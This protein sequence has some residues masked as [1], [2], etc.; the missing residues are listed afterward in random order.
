MF[1]GHFA[2]GFA[3]KRL[4]P[5]ASLGTLFMAAQF[6]DLLWPTFLLFGFERVIIE[7]GN[8]PF[9]PLNFVHYPWSH[10]LVAVINW[11][12]L[13][14]ATYFLIR[15]DWRTGLILGLVVISHWVLD[16]VT[17][18]PDLPLWPGGE[19]VGLGLWY[20]T[21]GTLAVEITF[22]VLGILMYFRSTSARD[23]TGQWTL[24]ILIGLLFVIY[25]GNVFGP[26]PPG[27]EAIAWVGQAQWLLVAFGYWVDRHR[28]ID[29]IAPSSRQF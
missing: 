27:V 10:S 28:D 3:G 14:G 22:F 23:S 18:A 29:E 15:H 16:L 25:L 5:R 24:W 26:P 13:F 12:L 8:T 1:L 19:R 7:P 11:G 6:I 9:T 2:I 17:H 21:A 20:S 4:A